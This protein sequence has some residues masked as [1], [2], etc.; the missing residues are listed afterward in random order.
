MTSLAPDTRPRRH[1]VADG[2]ADFQRAL[3]RVI[4]AGARLESLAPG[5]EPIAEEKVR[6]SWMRR[7][8]ELLA[9]RDEVLAGIANDAEASSML[10]VRAADGS[11]VAVDAHE[12]ES[13]ATRMLRHRS[14]GVALGF[15]ATPEHDDAP[16][17]LRAS[18]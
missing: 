10:R 1:A 5:G 2:E 18:A 9:R 15:V 11:I 17:A 3:G 13:L 12:L 8:G 4:V 16:S 6:S 7:A 14:A